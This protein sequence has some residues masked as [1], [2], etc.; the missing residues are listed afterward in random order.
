MGLQNFHSN[1]LKHRPA[2]NKDSGRTKDFF[3]RMVKVA[4]FIILHI[5]FVFS[6]SSQKP[7]IRFVF[8]GI[9]DNREF[10][11]GYSFPQTILGTRGTVEVGITMDDHR[12]V[13]G[14]SRLFEFGSPSDF[15]KTGMILY[16]Q[17]ERPDKTF[18]FGSFPRRGLI[19]FPLAML[20]DTLNYYRPHVEGIRGEIRRG[21][22]YQNAFIDWTGRQTAEVREAFTAASSGEI[23]LSDFFIQNYIILNHLAHSRPRGEGEH[24]ND[25]MGYSVLA[26][27]RNQS[28]DEWNICLKAGILGSLF[29]ERSV[30]DGM[31]HSTSLLSKGFMKYRNVA[32]RNTMHT[33]NGHHFMTG[34]P[35][36][37]ANH[38]MRTDIVWYFINHK[39]IRGHFNLSFHL[40]DWENL[41]QS[42]Q[43]SIIYELP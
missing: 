30:T 13:A 17:F 28:S 37:R 24:V 42:Q 14:L 20:T 40:S 29:R 22:S 19:D 1:N 34:D 5:C 12:L 25:N 33:G 7:D 39:N 36:Y 3:H 9:G 32:A 41:A 15:H 8:E 6:A 11:G 2:R 23:S 26:G 27:W 16:Y 18:H 38:Y 4:I 10:S 35:F 21:K 43:I 31:I